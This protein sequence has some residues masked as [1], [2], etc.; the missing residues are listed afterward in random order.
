MEKVAEDYG[1]HCGEPSC[2]QLDFLPHKCNSCGLLFCAHHSHPNEHHCSYTLS[3]IP[4]LRA[5]K[6][7]LCSQVIILEP[8]EDSNAALKRHSL[9]GCSS[10]KRRSGLV[11]C[12]Y[13]GCSARVLVP[14]F[15][16]YCNKRLCIRHHLPE[17]HTCTQFNSSH[18]ANTHSFPGNGNSV[19][20]KS[21]NRQKFTFG[22]QRAKRLKAKGD[23]KVGYSDKVF[24]D[25]R[26]PDGTTTTYFVNKNLVIGRIIDDVARSEHLRNNNN[27]P[28]E[29][30]LGLFLVNSEEPLPL[31]TRT[32]KFFS[33]GNDLYEAELRHTHITHKIK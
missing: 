26:L 11:K 20:S 2:N 9:K 31:D 7:E 19:Q 3:K 29:K 30:K 25:I 16:P 17:S 22:E 27:V 32:H 15:C 4:D 13:G 23:S 1:V 5:V 21:Q 14:I 6:C 8:Y 28:G 12:E 10:A 24:I 33:D 18:Q